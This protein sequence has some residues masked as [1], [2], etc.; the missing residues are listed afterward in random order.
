VQDGKLVADVSGQIFQLAPLSETHFR[1]VGGPVKVGVNFQRPDPHKPAVMSID[2]E[3]QQPVTLE[4]IEIVTPTSTQLAEY[5]GDY[6]SD[7]LQATY[8]IISEGGKLMLKRK[9]APMLPLSPTLKDQFA[10]GPANVSFIRNALNRVSG[11]TVNAGR[12]TNIR[13]VRNGH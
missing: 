10:A 4:A 12:V 5:V 7:E 8:K 3:D 13:F 2:V 11:F 6:Y 9:N 1:A